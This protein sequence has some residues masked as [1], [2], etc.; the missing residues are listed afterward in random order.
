MSA[1]VC[2]SIVAMVVAMLVVV[3]ARGTDG[4]ETYWLEPPN[5]TGDLAPVVS[6][7]ADPSAFDDAA[8]R[9]TTPVP[10]PWTWSAGEESASVRLAQGFLR[11][12]PRGSLRDAPPGALRQPLPSL[13]RSPSSSGLSPQSSS[14]GDAATL[15]ASQQANRDALSDLAGNNFRFFPGTNFLYFLNLGNFYGAGGQQIR[16]PDLVTFGFHATGTDLSMDPT[17]P[18]WAYERDGVGGPNDVFS[19]GPGRDTDGRSGVD[20]F[21]L[22][23]PLPPNEV[24]TSPGPDYVYAGGTATYTETNERRTPAPDPIQNNQQWYLEYSYSRGQLVFELPEVGGAAVRRV[25]LSENNS[26]IPRDRFFV[27]HRF[28][29]QVYR[30]F[31]D[32]NRYTFGAERT[33]LD[34]MSSLEVRFPFAATL[35]SDQTIGSTYARNFEAGNITL[36]LKDVLWYNEQLLVTTGLGFTFPSADDATVNLAGVGRIMTIRNESFHLLPYMAAQ[37]QPRSDFYMIGFLQLDFDT[38]GNS[39]LADITG[40]NLREIG[41]LQESTWLFADVSLGYSFYEASSSDSLVQRLTA[42]GELHYSTTLQEADS[43]SGNDIVVTSIS[44][45]SDVLNATAGLLLSTNRRS[46]VTSAVSVPLR[47]GDDRQFN[48]E[49]ITSFNLFY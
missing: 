45:R 9:A 39:V 23:E 4:G 10:F 5:A 49:L 38:G 24:E 8:A 42:I 20:T 6:H 35:D 3:S 41:V 7:R 2:Q 27:D 12:T 1:N 44:N 28:F 18:A 30:D 22:L 11:D 21:D 15:F 25:I 32:V 26:P 16:V 37:W 34:G 47:D 13:S 33:F 19:V 40:R 36:A 43:V 14:A 48:M 17:N 29:H 31:G 46:M